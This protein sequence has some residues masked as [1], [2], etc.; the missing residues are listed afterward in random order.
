MLHSYN[1]KLHLP[2]NNYHKIFETIHK[3]GGD[4]RLIGGIVRDA[5]LNLVSSDIDI[6]T[7][8]TPQQTIEIF[9]NI[10]AKVIPTGIAYGTVTVLYQDDIFEITTLR[11]DISTDGRRAS[12]VYTDNFILDAERRDFTINALSYDP[13]TNVLYDYFNGYDDL[14]NK[15]VRFIGNPEQ[16]I[17][18]DYLRILRFFRFSAKYANILDKEGL[19]ACIKYKTFLTNLSKER[20]KSEMDKLIIGPN[21]VNILSVINEHQIMPYIFSL[22]NFDVTILQQAKFIAESIDTTIN[23]STAYAIIFMHCDITKDKLLALKFSNQES[24]LILELLQLINYQEAE[25]LKVFLTEK[26]LTNNDYL[27]FF[28]IASVLYGQQGSLLGYLN[29]FNSKPLFPVNASH[30][31]KLGLQGPAIG[32]ALRKLRNIWI[33]E[34]FSPTTE[35]LLEYL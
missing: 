7:T 15:L 27:Q 29:S 33:K 28:I 11:Q 4:A 10:G 1:I 16:R 13:I 32:L 24:N 35:E 30:L 14:K 9:K 25:R 19:E 2:K 23:T 20:I 12:V 18:E 34:D 5:L 26:W 3:N 17:Q 21:N 6:A 22:K 8:L 31:Q